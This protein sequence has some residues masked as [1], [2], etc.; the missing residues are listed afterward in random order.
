MATT[1]Q[2]LIWEDKGLNEENGFTFFENV[3]AVIFVLAINEYDMRLRE[4]PNVNRMQESLDVFKRVIN[5]DYLKDTTIILFLN[6]T[7]LFRDKIARSDLR[8]CFP[9]YTGGPDYN[10][11]LSFIEQKF[12]SF[13]MNASRFIFTHPT[14]ATDTDNVRLVLS[15]VKLTLIQR[16]LNEIGILM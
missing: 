13:D 8:E 15:D 9:D 2:L 11:A 7:D 14:C 1:L 6:K 4:D 12:K 16:V 3:T 5:N 10:S